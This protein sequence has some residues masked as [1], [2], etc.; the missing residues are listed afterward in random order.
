M[1]KLPIHRNHLGQILIVIIFI[2]RINLF[3]D[4]GN[5]G[6]KGFLCDLND[7]TFQ[8]RYQFKPFCFFLSVYNATVFLYINRPKTPFIT[9][10]TFHAHPEMFAAYMCASLS[11]LGHDVLTPGHITSIDTLAISPFA[12]QHLI[13]GYSSLVKSHSG[14][15]SHENSLGQFALIQTLGTLLPSF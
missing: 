2:F 12:L 11:E 15:Q 9:K 13:F 14:G 4:Q 1:M 3:L 6:L 8:G 7:I 5:I 10:P